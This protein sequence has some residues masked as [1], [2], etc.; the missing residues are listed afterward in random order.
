[1]DCKTRAC[2]TLL[3]SAAL[4]CGCTTLPRKSAVD[5]RV[6]YS[7]VT[8]FNSV[9]TRIRYSPFE[10]SA[11]LRETIRQAFV[12]E[13]P[14]SY[15]I[16]PSGE[17]IYNYLSISGGGSDGAFGAGLINGWTE[18]GERPHFKVVTGVSA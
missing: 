2:L 6:E 15:V 3:V 17:H 13:T 11:S 14:D 10:D 4:L 8:D 18:S 12:T 9:A 16:G 5:A 1:M 7:I